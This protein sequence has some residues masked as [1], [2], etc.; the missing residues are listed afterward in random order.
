MVQYVR[1]ILLAVLLSSCCP[2]IDKEPLVRM[3]TL[4]VPVGFTDTITVTKQ[5]SFFVTGKT[6]YLQGKTVH[7]TLMQ[8]IVRPKHDTIKVPYPDTITVYKEREKERGFLDGI[9]FRDILVVGSVL[10]FI[11]FPLG[12]IILKVTK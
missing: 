4:Y 9:T 1:Y 11:V 3:D 6:V 7:D 12:Y 5:D 8:Y 2:K 10:L